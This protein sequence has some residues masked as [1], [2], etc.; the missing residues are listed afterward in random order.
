MSFMIKILD[1]KIIA[2]RHIFIRTI[3]G[4]ESLNDVNVNGT[5][6]WY[7][8]ICIREVWLMSHGISPNQDDSNI[9]LG[10]F[11]HED[12][13]SRD[14]KEIS[15]GNV[16]FDIL[17]EKDGYMMIGEVK[18]SS[19]Y[20]ESAKMQLAYYLLEL[21]RNG[22]DGIGVLMFPKEKKREEVILTDELIEELES[23]EKQILR[24]CYES[25]PQEPKKINFCKNC[26]YAEFCWS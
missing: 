26:A 14:K 12:S 10:R 25:A 13:Y 23:I 22:I 3:N 7:Y 11:I 21:K 9:D 2:E 8:T 4:G 20:I 16:K 17:S 6:V 1:S 18:K 24:I 15:I 19:K 5:L